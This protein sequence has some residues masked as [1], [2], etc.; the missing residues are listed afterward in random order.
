MAGKKLCLLLTSINFCYIIIL[1]KYNNNNGDFMSKKIFDFNS[2]TEDFRKLG[3]KE[4][5]NVLVH[6]SMK[7]IGEVEGGADT[8][9]D[10]FCAYLAENGNI[11]LPSHSWDAIGDEKD[12]FDP[13]SEPSCV[14]I[15]T[16]MFRKRK[17]VLR[18]LHPTHSVAV[19]GKDA[20]CFVKDEHLID[21]PCGRKGC[22][23]KLLD[24]DFKIIFIGCG[25]TSNTFIHG[26]EEWCGV[27][28]RITDGHQKLKIIM[29]DG[30]VFDRDMRRHHDSYGGV[31]E[32]YDRIRPYMEEKGLLIKGKFG[33]ADCM[34]QRAK[35]MY[36]IT[37][38]LLAQNID[39]FGGELLEE[40][41]DSE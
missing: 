39:F 1:E 14:G 28:G 18:S 32:R 36:E 35:D 2:L 11:A 3:I 34:V 40:E 25:N 33:N 23:G 31:S 4:Y 15:L 21:T 8:V 5:D 6:S 17:N 13:V 10:V 16:E 29:P 37:S 38:G 20:E 24:M 7:S 22:W 19:M 41:K 26:V 12:T 9:L 27:P 30:A